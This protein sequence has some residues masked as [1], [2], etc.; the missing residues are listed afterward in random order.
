MNTKF[1]FHFLGFKSD[2]FFFSRLNGNCYSM[3]T[4]FLSPACYFLLDYDS[5][6]SINAIRSLLH[7]EKDRT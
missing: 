2:F 4:L 3:T 1:G 7:E 5:Y 6:L